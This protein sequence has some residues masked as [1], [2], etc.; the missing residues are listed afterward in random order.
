[1]RL[2]QTS[3]RQTRE[4][5]LEFQPGELD[6]QCSG[7]AGVDFQPTGGTVSFFRWDDGLWQL[8]DLRTSGPTR[9]K[10]GSLGTR[11]ANTRFF[12]ESDT[13]EPLW[14]A[15]QETLAELNGS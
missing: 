9:K 1:M 12:S 8:G 7:Y 2:N 5:T 6:D 11:E 14:R 13:P 15:V 3:H 4:F 10:N